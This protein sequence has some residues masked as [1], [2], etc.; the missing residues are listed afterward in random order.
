LDYE[1]S[2]STGAHEKISTNSFL[3][4]STVSGA[5]QPRPWPGG[6]AVHDP[7]RHFTAVN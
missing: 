3:P 6:A 7:Q 4:F 5:K 2:V 1:K